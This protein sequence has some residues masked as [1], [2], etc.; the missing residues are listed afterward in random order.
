M[1]TTPTMGWSIDTDPLV[2][3]H[4]NPTTGEE[5]II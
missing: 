2:V 4:A 5:A 1:Q 3:L